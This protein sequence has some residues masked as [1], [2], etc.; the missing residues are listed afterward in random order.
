MFAQKLLT[1]SRVRASRAA[2]ARLAGPLQCDG[3]ID[4]LSPRHIAGWAYDAR[5]GNHRVRLEVVLDGP[6]GFTARPLANR[7]VHGLASAGKGD[8][9]H[10][11]YTK[12][13]RALTEAEQARVH[14]RP[15]A[16]ALPLHVVPWAHREYTPLLHVAM[17]IVDNCNLR[18]PF[19]LYDYVNTNATH[20]M[21]EATLTAA[22]RFLPYTRD[23]EF[24]FSCLHEPA[25]HPRLMDFI[26]LVP[27]EYRRKLFFTSNIAKRMPPGY[28]AWLADS[29]LHHINISIESRDPAIYER[30][31]KGARYRIFAANWDLL[32]QALPDGSAPPQIRYIAM[33][34]KSNLRELPELVAYLLAERQAGQVELRYTY[35]VPHI[36]ADFKASE[37]L[38]AED[39]H[40]LKDQLAGYAPDKVV[41]IAPPN[42]APP[43]VPAAGRAASRKQDDPPP[44]P[45]LPPDET[46]IAPVLSGR[47]MFRV[48][49]DGSVRV[50]GVRQDSRG[51]DARE[52]QLM[53]TNIRDLP[54]PDA[55]F[56]QLD[57]GL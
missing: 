38:A 15:A 31:R 47:Y 4:E 50:Q 11:F 40:W 12:F 26:D 35:D 57:A 19:C 48:S 14:V 52:R 16:S 56:A 39:W 7:F 37:Y 32:M 51:E 45:L 23:G 41:L 28:F 55:L 30:M 36:P 46:E 33:A 27:R 5:D 44:E 10:G 34:Y 9:A 3:G 43:P 1:G 53:N 25:L 21:D 6:D 2:A 29:G 18:C 22:L 54:D 8:G 17:D 49:W 42:D 20:M 13:P 24:W